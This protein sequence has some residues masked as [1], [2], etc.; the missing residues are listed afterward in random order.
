[1]AKLAL[2]HPAIAVLPYGKKM[3]R[4]FHQTSLA[5]LIWPF[6]CPVRLHGKHVKDLLPTDHLISFV[7]TAMHFQ[8]RARIP[9]NLSII[10]GEPKAISSKHHQLLRLTQ[11]RFFRVMTHNRELLGRL[12]NGIFLPFGM[13][14]VPD[15]Q[16]VD[17]AK[18]LE[19]SLIASK[20]RD[21]P[22]HKLRHKVADAL[23][24]K[25]CQLNANVLGGGY[26]P[27]KEKSLGL[28]PYRYSV[29]I[30]NVSEPDYFTEKLVDCI[31]CETVPIYWGCPNIGDFFPE[32][33]IICCNDFSELRDAIY[34]V[35]EQDYQ[36]RLPRVRAAKPAA[37]HWGDLYL[38]AA[39]GLLD[40][41]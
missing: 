10:V 29:V 17:V 14:W 18:T 15:W 19:L 23:L 25:D 2:N 21:L 5:D 41:L 9:A 28:A 12:Q 20:K 40:T 36:N 6:G 38:R 24:H 11:K 7:K 34:Q 4:N 32:G 37:A 22:G 27:F 31:L 3:G 16:E 30:E 26:K 1:M 33:S 13:T 8:S 39:Q 35:S